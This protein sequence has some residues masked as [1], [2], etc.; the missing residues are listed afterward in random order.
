MLDQYARAPGQGASV[1]REQGAVRES[2]AKHASKHLAKTTAPLVR[3]HSAKQDEAFRK[4]LID[5]QES[6][7]RQ[8]DGDGCRNALDPLRRALRFEPFER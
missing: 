1:E 8:D 6:D 7:Q 5:Q 3:V 4:L 2:E